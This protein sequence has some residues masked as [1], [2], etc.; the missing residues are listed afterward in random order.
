MAACP[1]TILRNQL[2]RAKRLGYD[3]K[4]GLELEYFLVQRN[5]DGSIGSPT[6]DDLDKPCCMTWRA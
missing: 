1:R 4:I 2:A 5:D 3:F 6:P